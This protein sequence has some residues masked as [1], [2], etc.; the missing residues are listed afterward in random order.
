M[1]PEDM[2]DNMPEDELPQD[3]EGVDVE[4]EVEVVTADMD[5]IGKVVR[6]KFEEAKDF[7]Q[8]FEDLWEDAYDAYRGQY[9]SRLDHSSELASTRGIY[10]NQTRRKV[11]SAR[12]KIGALLFDD[13]RIPFSI[14]P[15]RKPRFVPPDIP[16]MQMSKQQIEDAVAQRAM[17]M[18]TKIRDLMDRTGYLQSILDSIFELCLYGTGVTK[19]PTLEYI[20]FPVFKSASTPEGIYDVE[21]QIESELVP[22]TKFVSIWNVFPSPEALNAADADYIIQRTFLSETQ[23]MDLSN[24]R[25]GFFPEAIDEVL[26]KEIG[27]VDGYGNS[28]HPKRA[29]EQNSVRVKRYEVL[30]F[31]G[32]MSIKDLEGHIDIPGDAKGYMDVVVHV[33]GNKVI[34]ISANPFDGQKPFHFS[35]WQKRP[36][37][38]WGDGIYYSIRD[39]QSLI[40]F[41]YAMLVE[42][43]TLSSVPMTVINPAAMEPGQDTEKIKAGKQFRVK[44]G[45]SV[46]DAFQSIIIPDVTNGLVQLIQMLEREA[47]LDSSQ[48]AIG[49]GETSASQTRTATGMSILNSNSNKQ[50]ADVV[51]S[52]SDMITK[53]VQSMY[54]WLMVDNEDM[55]IKGDYEA[56]STGWTQYV[57]KE[58][59]NTQLI[60]FL[61]T[62]GNIPMLQN[63]IR[64]N[65]FAQPLARAFNLDPENVIKT[66]EEIAQETQQAQQTQAQ[67]AQQAEQIK[68]QSLQQELTLRSQFERAKAILEEKKAVSEDIRQSQIQ[69]RLEL[70]RSGATL[71]EAVPNYYGMSQLLQE[72]AQEKQAQAQQQMAAQQ[73]QA[74]QAQMAQ[75]QQEQA[76]IN[77]LQ[78][79]RLQQIARSRQEGVQQNLQGGP[80]SE[81]LMREQR[82]N[83]EAR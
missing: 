32:R 80:S 21:S 4:V 70:M 40:N 81:E 1:T 47:D 39:V 20:N 33:V 3:E 36:E 65:N 83:P 18:E 42:G 25:E 43:K 14:T 51:R 49:Y 34:K 17:N 31:W 29:E 16:A 71:K 26:E 68:N 77:Q 46:Q 41:A 69:E 75:R 54:H 72:E 37:Q 64:F 15:S 19:S 48:T 62:V 13:G 66:Q 58:V 50:T 6:E 61:S 24:Y 59:H 79:Q 63:Q 56:I 60:N 5:D 9:P 10:I 44:S 35:Y 57:A 67:Q 53:N 78:Q 82:E 55:S 7:R 27:I 45:F 23:L 73:Q 52:I 22:A 8:D 76:M 30:E 74:A 38:I 2:I 12:V 11:N 28:E